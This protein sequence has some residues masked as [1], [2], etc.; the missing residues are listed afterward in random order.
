MKSFLLATTALVSLSSHLFAADL[1]A[2]P[3]PLAPPPALSWAGF[4]TGGQVGYLWSRDNLTQ[5]SGTST[6]FTARLRPDAFAGGVH[7]GYQWQPD[8]IVFG[9][10]GDVDLANPSASTAFSNG[11]DFYRSIKS[12]YRASLRARLGVAF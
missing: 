4:Y 11:E 2:R 12:T 10:E 1:G 6:L 7:A 9:V 3:S 8:A 5:T